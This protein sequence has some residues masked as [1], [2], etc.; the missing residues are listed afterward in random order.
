MRY[1][2]SQLAMLVVLPDDPAP[3]ALGKLE[4]SIS[5][6]TFDAW[7]TALRSHRVTVSLPR[8]KFESGGPLDPAL[9]E[10]GMRAAYSSKADFSGIAEPVNGERLQITRV[11]QR[12]YVSVDEN[13]TEAAASTGVGHERHQ[14]LPRPQRRLQGRSPVPVLRVRRITRSHPLRRSRHRPPFLISWPHQETH[15]HQPARLGRRTFV[16]TSLATGFALAVSPVGAQTI[17]TDATG[18]VAGEVKIGEM[19]AYRAMPE[20]GASSRS[21]SSCPEIFGVH[22]HIKDVCRR[23]AKA[24]YMAI[25][26]ELFARQGDVSKMTDIGE[27]ISKVVSKVPDEQVMRDLD[28]TVDWAKKSGK[29]DGDRVG[30]TGFCWG[31]RIVW[32]YSAHNGPGGA[33]KAGA[34]WYGPLSQRRRTR[35]RRGPRSTSPAS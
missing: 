22:E 4:D 11:V 7:T 2:G 20:G 18:L 9:Q 12:T 26:P 8:F 6:D 34:A 24:G 31:G 13:G 29:V 15:G 32:L 10:L 19:P 30:I 1:S 14:R 3:A 21:S 27:I 16:V 5:S 28:A 23:L 33:P 25:A 17:T 35:C